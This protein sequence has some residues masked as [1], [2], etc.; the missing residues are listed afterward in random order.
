MPAAVM[1]RAQDAGLVRRRSG[2][3]QFAPRPV[4]VGVRHPLHTSG[5]SGGVDPLSDDRARRSARPP[6]LHAHGAAALTNEEAER[7]MGSPLPWP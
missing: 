7:V 1:H 4:H 3:D 5:L 2:S 6:G